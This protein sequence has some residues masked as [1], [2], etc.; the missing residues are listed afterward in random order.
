MF[1]AYIKVT[2]TIILAVYN[3]LYFLKYIVGIF[4]HCICWCDHSLTKNV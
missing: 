1:Y 2:N 4:M 3:I